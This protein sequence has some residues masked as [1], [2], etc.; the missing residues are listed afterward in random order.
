[1]G[2]IC[3]DCKKDMSKVDGCTEYDM[4]FCDRAYRRIK[5][6]DDNMDNGGERCPDC[7]VKVGHTHHWGCDVERCPVCKNQLISCECW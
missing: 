5:F 7:N 2:A 4:N 6:G 1:M 3:E